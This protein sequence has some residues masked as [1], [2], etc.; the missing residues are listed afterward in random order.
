MFNNLLRQFSKF[1]FDLH[2]KGVYHKD[3]SAGNILITNSDRGSTFN[4]I[5]LNR[6]KFVSM[7]FDM[8]MQNFNRLTEDVKVMKIMAEEY[9]ALSPWSYDD[10]LE[11]MQYYTQKFRSKY[12]F[13]TSMKRRF[14]GK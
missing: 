2:E 12:N 10:I 13:R 4:L 7:D 1:V 6:T 11:K 3:L 14:L 8:R 5:D 9:A